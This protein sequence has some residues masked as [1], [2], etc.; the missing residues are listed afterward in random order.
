MEYRRFG[1]TDMT[2]SALGFGCWEMGGTYGDVTEA[3]VSAAVN[4]AI[5]PGINC[6]GTAPACGKGES[7]ILLRRRDCRAALAMTV[8]RAL[9][10]AKR[11]RVSAPALDNCCRIVYINAT[12]ILSS[13]RVL[14][15]IWNG[16][17]LGL[18]S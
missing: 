12:F 6:F 9:R 8:R 4:R 7:E 15:I 18:E 16:I 3:E 14:G 1:P 17:F 10:P 11:V 5:D 13:C 2:V